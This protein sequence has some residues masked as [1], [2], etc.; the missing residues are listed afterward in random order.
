MMVIKVIPGI[1]RGSIPL[2][3]YASTFCSRILALP[4]RPCFGVLLPG[5]G[6]R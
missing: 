5:R 2:P 3:A 1:A 4:R 6:I